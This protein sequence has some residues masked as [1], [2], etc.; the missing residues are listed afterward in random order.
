[1]EKN[2]IYAY[3]CKGDNLIIQ[4]KEVLRYMSCK[5]ETPDI[6]SLIDSCLPEVKKAFNPKGSFGYFDLELKDNIVLI[7]GLSINSK[8]LSKNLSGCKSAVVFALTLGA[9][10]DRLINRYQELS[11]SKALCIN[12]IATAAVESLADRFCGE[13]YENIKDDGLY[14]R[15]RFSAGY[16]D[17]SIK[18]QRQII[19]L[20]NGTKL[21]GITLTDALMMVPVKSVT[22]IMGI[23]REKTDCHKHSCE[24][25][26]KKNCK[27]RR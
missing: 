3:S 25:C 4:E 12:A 15:P 5:E 17:F 20:V 13:V 11:P 27:F 16:G 19:D 22:A 26:D 23:S 10:I 9:E 14:I 1:M 8:N 18:Y 2:I 24:D 6:K 7:S 21:N